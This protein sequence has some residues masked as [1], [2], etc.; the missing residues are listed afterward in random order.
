MKVLKFGGSSVASSQSIRKVLEIVKQTSKN[1]K[2][3]VV[4]S[5]FG[6]TTNRLLK[7]ANKAVQNLAYKPLLQEVENHHLLV[8]KELIP[9]ANQSEVISYVKRLFNDLETLFEGCSLLQEL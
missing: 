8:I 6:K 4:V 7:T 3:I 5:A 9:V 2:T 1:D